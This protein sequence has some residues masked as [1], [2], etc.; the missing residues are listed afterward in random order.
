M[1]SSRCNDKSTLSLVFINKINLNNILIGSQDVVVI[2][3]MLVRTKFKGMFYK[4][5]RIK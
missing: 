3:Y 5:S 1:Y 4:G 2:V